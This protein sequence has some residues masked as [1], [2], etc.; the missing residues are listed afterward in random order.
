[1]TTLDAVQGGRTSRS[2]ATNGGAGLTWVRNSAV[3]LAIAFVIVFAGAGQF[4]GWNGLVEWV[5]GDRY[6][7]ARGMTQFTHGERGTAELAVINL[8]SRPL[9]LRGAASS[10][11][12]VTVSGL[13]LRIETGEAGAVTIAFDG[14]GSQSEM[15]LRFYVDE[16]PGFDHLIVVRH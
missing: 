16:G 3:I 8:Q 6:R 11:H 5:R 15:R 10:C 12:C 7:V 2:M 4:G 13:P 14:G 9:M 1:M